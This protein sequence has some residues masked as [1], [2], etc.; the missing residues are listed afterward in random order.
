MDGT[1]L[2]A[3]VIACY[4]Q[5]VPHMP[6]AISSAT[7]QQRYAS[8]FCISWRRFVR[9]HARP[10]WSQ[11]SERYTLW[12]SR[13]LWHLYF[14]Y[15]SYWGETES[16]WYCSHYWPIV[17]APDDRRW[18][19]WSNWW[20]EDWYGNPKYS[21][22]TC[23]SATLSTTNSTWPNPGSNPGPLSWKPATNRLS[24]GAASVIY[25][26]TKLHSRKCLTLRATQTL[27]WLIPTGLVLCPCLFLLC[28][29]FRLLPDW[30]A[31][32]VMC[33]ASVFYKILI[34]WILSKGHTFGIIQ[35]LLCRNRLI[36][37][38][39]INYLVSSGRFIRFERRCDRKYYC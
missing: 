13:V 30:R 38:F 31:A 11:Y 16:T 27:P 35:P 26:N 2:E 37:N 12:L 32:D 3:E 39:M 18:W 22:K 33:V 36:R 28:L 10:S 24:Y 9:L 15:Y 34:F 17:P 6:I 7:Q 8:C 1:I 19:L 4:A 23:P 25:L 20:I 14:C 5:E 21:E 29:S